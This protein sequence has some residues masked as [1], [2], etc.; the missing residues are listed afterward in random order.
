MRIIDLTG[1]R[2]GALTVTGRAIRGNGRTL[3]NCRCDC[4]NKCV[5]EGY[6]LRQGIVTSCGCGMHRA[7]LRRGVETGVQ[8]DYTG[9]SFGRLTAIRRVSHGEWLWKCDCGNETIAK[10]AD[11]KK[12]NP[13]SCGCGLKEASRKRIVEDNVLEFFDGTS[14]S[15]L[16]SI[17]AGKI[18]STN[19]SGYTGIKIRHNKSGDTYV[20]RIMV[21]GKQ[22]NLG[23][24]ATIEEA[25]DARKKAEKKYFGAIIEQ[26]D[27]QN[28]EDE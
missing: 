13:A 6:N 21:R 22:I 10:P 12:G 25:A 4:G 11:V 27:N 3:W 17:V 8:V 26:Y 24:Y 23:T 18:R 28:G 1:Q 20:A 16:R 5:Q 9:Q 19:T 7:S 2:F 14:V 15:N